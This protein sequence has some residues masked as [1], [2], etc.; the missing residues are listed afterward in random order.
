[1]AGHLLTCAT[2]VLQVGSINYD[3]VRGAQGSLAALEATDMSTGEYQ[4]YIQSWSSSIGGNCNVDDGSSTQDTQLYCVGGDR[5]VFS[6]DSRRPPYCDADG[7]K[8]TMAPY[9]AQDVDAVML[10]AQ[11]ATY[12][13]SSR[14]H[15]D[16]DAPALYSAMQQISRSAQGLSS[17][18]IHLDPSG[19]RLGSLTILNLQR[20]TSSTRR[21]LIALQAKVA[22]YVRVGSFETA[23]SS[24]DMP[25]P[26]TG[27]VRFASGQSTAPSDGS[28]SADSLS[29]SVSATCDLCQYR[30]CE[31]SVS[32]FYS[33]QDHCQVPDPLPIPC[34][35]SA[36]TS[37]AVFTLCRI[38]IGIGF[39]VVVATCLLI[40]AYFID[41]SR[42]THTDQRPLTQSLMLAVAAA[43]MAVSP[44]YFAG[45]NTDAMCT[46]RPLLSL[47]ACTLTMLGLLR[48][49]TSQRGCRVLFLLGSACYLATVVILA[50]QPLQAHKALVA[51]DAK[52]NHSW[53]TV[54]DGQI[55][56]QNVICSVK[57]RSEMESAAEP[58]P[59]PA[60]PPPPAPPVLPYPHWFA[61][62]PH[63]PSPSHAPSHP[64][65]PPPSSLT[66]SPPPK[67]PVDCP[68]IDA[69]PLNTSANVTIGG[70]TYAYPSDYGLSKCSAHDLMLPPYCDTANS[71]GHKD[72]MA[73]CI[74]LGR[75]PDLCFAFYVVTSADPA[76][77][78]RVCQANPQFCFDSWCYVNPASCNVGFST[79]YFGETVNLTYSY[80][81]CDSHNKFNTFFSALQP[82]HPPMPPPASPPPWA[83][84]LPFFADD[85]HL[86]RSLASTSLLVLAVVSLL[87][88]V[89]EVVTGFCTGSTHSGMRILIN[90]IT[91]VVT[92]LHTV[93]VAISE[94]ASDV[95]VS[96]MLISVSGLS[97]ALCVVLL[98]MVL[99]A[100]DAKQRNN[101]RRRLRWNI[102][103][104]L[105][106]LPP[107]SGRWRFDSFLSH[108]WGGGTQE[109]MRVVKQELLVLLPSLRVFLDVVRRHLPFQPHTIPI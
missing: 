18:S 27:A 104:G 67:T 97:S 103:G 65:L 13:Y 29:Y 95:F 16:H 82:R 94:S 66:P 26:G 15:Y 108:V 39:L 34:D 56:A 5:C 80:A 11:A 42:N 1:V 98:Q 14:G 43:V 76:T 60:A 50:V 12:L 31:R 33:G 8:T 25:R 47:H 17:R 77:S 51:Y 90:S 6:W 28:C 75:V 96:Y 3:A 63:A 7:N 68:C 9:A 58:A 73:T 71:T 89:V 30:A 87:Q 102:D 83:P 92:G 48:T 100:R 64:P 23:S 93:L 32:F 20:P 74:T 38:G 53:I 91:L 49:H 55:D 69:Y 107:L 2:R 72:P 59:T 10:F 70:S 81:A 84:P 54:G 36:S 4:G 86:E 61:T 101:L 105:V 62:P 19:D 41:M 88:I 109:K 78:C 37:L 85:D 40:R 46:L 44:I 21:R 45:V 24:L 106:Q 52:R 79:V 99:P 57:R 35:H 22:E